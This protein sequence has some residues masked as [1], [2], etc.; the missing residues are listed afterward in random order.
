MYS[1]RF[2]VMMVL[3]CRMIAAGENGRWA[4]KLTA[5]VHITGFFWDEL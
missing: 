1:W 5:H 3:I 4:V 2:E